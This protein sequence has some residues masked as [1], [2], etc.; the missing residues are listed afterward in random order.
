MK[1]KLIYTVTVFCTLKFDYIG[2]TAAY[3][4]AVILFFD[5]LSLPKLRSSF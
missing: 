3:R 5:Y 2:L 4:K 1:N